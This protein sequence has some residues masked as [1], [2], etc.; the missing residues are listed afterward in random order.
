V[1]VFVAHVKNVCSPYKHTYT[2]LQ[3]SLKASLRTRQSFNSS[4]EA[5]LAAESMGLLSSA[6]ADT[7]SR[8]PPESSG[9]PQL[10]RTGS[11]VWRRVVMQCL[12]VGVEVGVGG[13]GG[14]GGWG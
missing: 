4:Q 5:A 7:E 2:A 3:A 11:G 12:C 10:R 1:Y 14:L 8:A 13:G 9:A 6:G